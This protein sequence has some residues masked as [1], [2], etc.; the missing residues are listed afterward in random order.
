MTYFVCTM[1]NTWLILLY[2]NFSARGA[3]KGKV[4]LRM[5]EENSIETNS[6]GGIR[7]T[8]S[9]WTEWSFPGDVPGSKESEIRKALIFM[10]KPRK[11][12]HWLLAIFWGIISLKKVTFLTL[13]AYHKFNKSILHLG[14]LLSHSHLKCYTLLFA[15]LMFRRDCKGK[16]LYRCCSF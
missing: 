4:P 3:V 1:T 6:L 8:H 14:I 13:C 12:Q 9:I 7:L 10:L 16:K 2:K 11:G 5:N 15:F